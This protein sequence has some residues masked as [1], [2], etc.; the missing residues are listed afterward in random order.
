[1]GVETSILYQETARRLTEIPAPPGRLL[2]EFDRLQ[3]VLRE[4]G[5][6]IVRVFPEYTPHDPSLHLDH[7]L[8]LADRLLGPAL[9]QRLNA[10]EL[11]VFLFALFAHDW[12]MAVSEVEQSKLEGNSPAD[13]ELSLLPNEPEA[14]RIYLS[15]AS[16]AGLSKDHAWAN[17]LRRTHGLRSGARLRR[18][19]GPLSGPFAE[20]VARAAEGHTLAADD[21]RD[22]RA[23]PAVYPLFGQIVNLAAIANYVRI[24]D[25]LDIGEDRTP[26]ALWKFVQPQHPVSA[27]EWRKHRSLSAVSIRSTAGVRQVVVGGATDDVR[28]YA[29]LADLRSWIDAEFQDS[30]TNTRNLGTPYSLDLDTRIDWNVHALGFEPVLARFEMDRL[31][32]LGLLSREL[33]EAQPYAFVRELLL[34]S[35]DAI[36]ARQA[37]LARLGLSLPGQI[38]ITLAHETHGTRIR[39]IDNG[40]G[41]DGHVIRNYF[42]IIGRSWYSSDDYRNK[43]GTP[44]PLSKFGIGFLSCFSVADSV[45]LRTRADPSIVDASPG[46]CLDIPDRGAYFRVARHEEI[47]VGTAVEL[48]IGRKKNEHFSAIAFSRYLERFAAFVRHEIFLDIDGVHSKLTSLH[49]I[50]KATQS[51]ASF[52]LTPYLEIQPAGPMPDDLLG[53]MT[54]KINFRFGDENKCYQGYYS[55]LIPL[56]IETIEQ[57]DNWSWS[58]SGKSVNLHN[59]IHNTSDDVFVKGI[60]AGSLHL[61]RVRDR[62]YDRPSSGVNHNSDW[63]GPKISTNL[64]R[65]SL[66]SFN[67][68][69]T[70]ADLGSNDWQTQMW[71]EICESVRREILSEDQQSPLQRA[72]AIGVASQCAGIPTDALRHIV[73]TGQWPTL[74]L[75]PGEGLR[76]RSLSDFVGAEEIIE[77]PLEL[78]QSSYNF[79]RS[80]DF[81]PEGRRFKG[82]QGPPILFTKYFSHIAESPY[83]LDSIISPMPSKLAEAGFSPCEIAVIQPGGGFEGSLISKMW[84]KGPIPRNQTADDFLSEDHG[85]VLNPLLLRETL[86]ASAPELLPFPRQ[87]SHLGAIGSAYWNA[88]NPHVVAIVTT[89]LRLCKRVQLGEASRQSTEAYD[90]LNSTRYNGYAFPSCKSEPKRALGMHAGLLKIAATEKLGLCMPLTEAEFLPGSVAR[91]ESPHQF[92]CAIWDREPSASG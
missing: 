76:L 51:K 63:I 71:Q 13:V 27:L 77:A 52:E 55:A 18:S 49:D 64:S 61:N 57:V 24:V 85:V 50:G 12:G 58:F 80:V 19:L 66:V 29:A 45:S 78:T 65:P 74:A 15:Q 83:W 44:E 4:H 92:N 39:W 43:E 90:H 10:T 46:Y 28:V 17:Y 9:Y 31:A 38:Q 11:V 84:K 14:S 54:R 89:L 1:M 53:R 69:R 59:Y 22:V 62:E 16:A 8:P 56:N 86:D 41:M 87:L 23:Y 26:F 20:A 37:L 6:Y 91:Y 75:L 72:W 67:L 34:N 33:Y 88:G 2:A 36:D 7:L 68:A 60:L 32:V 3:D 73:P 25:L 47:P 21:I 40:I 82:W 79:V 35:V 70:S 5:K 48:F 42:S 81:R 30:I